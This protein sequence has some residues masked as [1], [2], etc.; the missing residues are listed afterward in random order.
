MN[1]DY[2]LVSE[3]I[4]GTIMYHVFYVNGNYKAY[5]NPQNM[6]SH[7]WTFLNN[8]NC[9]TEILYLENNDVWQVQSYGKHFENGKG[10]ILKEENIW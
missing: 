7:V 3:D 4:N 9:P 1:V 2:V 5:E 10:E 8:F 6:P